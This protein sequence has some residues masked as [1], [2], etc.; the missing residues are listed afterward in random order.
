MKYYKVKK[1]YDNWNIYKLKNNKFIH[2]GFLISCE[3]KTPSEY[4]KL[5]ETI[6]NFDIRKAFYPVEV[7]KNNTYWFFGARF[8]NV[9]RG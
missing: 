5:C 8:E 3:L 4:K 6:K 7:K 9:K 1:E 2:D